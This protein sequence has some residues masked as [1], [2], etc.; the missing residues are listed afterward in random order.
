MLILGTFWEQLLE[1]FPLKLE[2]LPILDEYF[3]TDFNK[4]NHKNH[5]VDL[6]LKYIIFNCLLLTIYP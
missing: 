5:N 6:V 2:K 3:C 1:T 4:Y